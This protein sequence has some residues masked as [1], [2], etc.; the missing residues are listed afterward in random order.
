MYKFNQFDIK[1]KSTCFQGEKIKMSKILNKEI[2]VEAF[3]IEESKVDA[4]KAKGTGLCLHLQITFND[5]KHIV[6]TSSSGL[7]EAI[8]QVPYDGFP[9]TTTII[10]EGER[11]LFT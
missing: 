2:T 9:F 7:V 10:Q 5:E 4:F 1:L 6:F 11:Y 8:Q 3:K